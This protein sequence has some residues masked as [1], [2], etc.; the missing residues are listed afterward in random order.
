[1]QILRGNARDVGNLHLFYSGSVL[2]QKIGRVPVEFVRHALAQ[3]LFWCIKIEDEGIQDRVLGLLNFRLSN[4]LLRQ[5]IDLL[6]HRLNGFHGALAL[7]PHR[8][9]QNSWM[10]ECRPNSSA[11]RIGQ[12]LRGAN[13]SEKPGRKAATEC[14]IEHFDGIVIGIPARCP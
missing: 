6:I 7:G 9:A 2:F 12:T 4:R 14:F 1:M 8:E 13:V 10:I 11:N 5:V 3:D